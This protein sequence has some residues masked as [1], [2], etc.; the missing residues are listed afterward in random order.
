MAGDIKLGLTGFRQLLNQP[1][2]DLDAVIGFKDADKTRLDVFGKGTF[3]GRSV[4]TLSESELLAMKQDSIYLRCRLLKAVGQ[5]VGVG[6]DAFRRAQ[7]LLLGTDGTGPAS[8]NPSETPLDLRTIR[9]VFEAVANAPKQ[10]KE[11]AIKFKTQQQVQRMP[12]QEIVMYGMGTQRELAGDGIR[13][14][15]SGGRRPPKTV[16]I[17]HYNLYIGLHPSMLADGQNNKLAGTLEF[18]ANLRNPNA[19]VKVLDLKKAVKAGQ[20]PEIGDEEVRKWAKFMKDNAGKVDVL[21]TIGKIRNPNGTSSWSK[22]SNEKGE[23]YA[24]Q[25]FL[26]KNLPAR[27]RRMIL[28]DTEDERRLRKSENL[29]GSQVTDSGRQDLKACGRLLL[30]LSKMRENGEPMTM[31]DIRRRMLDIGRELKAPWVGGGRNGNQRLARLLF[32]V[33][34]ACSYA[35][36]RKT[37]KLGLDF[38]SQKGQAVVFQWSDHNLNRLDDDDDSLEVKWWRKADEE[39]IYNLN[40]FASI[41]NSEMRKVNHGRLGNVIKV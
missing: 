22:L 15:A 21:E 3:N 18:I 12:S 4:K 10:A 14:M 24:A 32:C 33:G 31:S 9:A 37:S 7:Q 17:D 25:T 6:S 28:M 36:F 20:L 11:A 2:Q 35:L 39:A 34:E 5:S 38:F 41:T 27:Y 19:P 23:E 40:D 13:S 29:D 26:V 30:E 1:E 16:F 8:L